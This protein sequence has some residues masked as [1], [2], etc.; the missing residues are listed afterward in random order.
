MT[1]W[2]LTAAVIIALAGCQEDQQSP[3]APAAEPALATTTTALSFR[4]VSTGY[5]HTCGLTTDDRAY[6]WGAGFDGQLGTGTTAQ[7]LRPAAVVG[8][9]RFRQVSAGWNHTCGVTTDYKAYCWG[10]NGAGQLG[11]GTQNSCGD[12][13]PPC[14]D[15][16]TN[17]N[18]LA[19]VPVLGGLQ[20]RQVDAGSWHTCGVT[21][22][23]R[24][25]CWGQNF[26]GQLGIGGGDRY[27]N[28]PTPVAVL[29]SHSF[30][31]VS[32]GGIHT[33][34]ITTGSRAFCW[35]SNR[36]GQ[37]GD[38][39]TTTRRRPVLVAGGHLFRQASAGGQQQGSGYTCAVTT[40]DRA[41]CWGDGRHGQLGDGNTILRL[42]PRAVVGGLSFRQVSAGLG[43]TCA[44]T[45]TNLAYCWG[46]NFFGEIGNGTTTQ[47]S[48]PVAVMGGL[49]FAQVSIEGAHHACGT[50]DTNLAYCWGYNGV[51]ELGD[52]TQTTRLKPRAVVGP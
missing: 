6:C 52:G 39:T 34:G 27:L 11:D 12:P 9:L 43:N 24:A 51:G 7:H 23:D 36:Y 8:G 2:P 29:S 13:N 22:D 28:R 33:C 3:T 35:G 26:Y 25:Y 21:R 41:F 30:R 49:S 17:A 5:F 37:V 42:T 48:K 44:R 31:Q 47:S 46:D 10:N 40:S 45:P 15:P 14:T 50:T 38:G 18:R 32:A 4:Q 1:R 20:F 19:P 16:E